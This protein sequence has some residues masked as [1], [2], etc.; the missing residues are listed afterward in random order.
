MKMTIV[1]DVIPPNRAHKG[2][3]AGLDFYTPRFKESFL[4][5]MKE[6][7]PGLTYNESNKTFVIEPGGRILIP[8]GVKVIVPDNHAL[9]AFNKSGIASKLGLVIGACVVDVGYRG[10]IHINLINTSNDPVIISE[11]M[12]VVQFILMPVNL[13]EP[14]FIHNE[15]YDNYISHRGD[16][17]FGSTD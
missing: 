5:D 2:E 6:K 10:E 7:N 1:R 12:K 17:A 13:I 15:Y 4:S 16:G 3:D 9:V 11:D 8:S 14:E